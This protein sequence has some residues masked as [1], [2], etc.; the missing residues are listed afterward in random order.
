M[1][2]HPI[3]EH[4]HELDLHETSGKKTLAGY[5]IGLVL[6]VILTLI[7]FAVIEYRVFNSAG[8]YISLASLA[9]IQL[10]VQSIFFLR[11][12]ASPEGKWNLMPFLF[13]ILIIAILVSGSLW[14]MYNLNY[15]MTT[16]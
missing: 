1:S 9:I 12:N 8:L 3:S 6:C 10:F 5:V 11:L 4:H 13:S 7:S 16:H 15:N 2:Q 14:I